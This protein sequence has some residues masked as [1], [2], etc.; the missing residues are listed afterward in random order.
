VNR[1]KLSWVFDVISPFSYLSLKEFYRLPA[2]IEFEY[3][4]VLFAG[5]L[6]HF[7]QVGPAEITSKR[8]WTYRF[9]LW[10]ARTLGIP[11]RFPPAHPFNPLLALRLIIAAGSNHRAVETVFDAVFLHGR[12]VSDRAV[13]ADLAQKLNIANPEQALSDPA[14]KQKLRAN[15][16]WAIGRGVFGVPT[17]VIGEEIFWAT[18]RSTWY[19]TTSAIRNPLKIPKCK[20]SNPCPSVSGGLKRHKLGFRM[21]TRSFR[22]GL[23]RMR[24][25]NGRRTIEGLRGR[26]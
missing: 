26:A 16:E 1:V 17:F 11:M 7:G 23:M 24:W 15:T 25:G 21:L 20:D 2:S 22:A 19:S 14:V 4:P 10:R 8:Q 9:V 6:K 5:L 18:T 3:I 13:I 12:D